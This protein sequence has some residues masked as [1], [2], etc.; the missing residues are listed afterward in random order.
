MGLMDLYQGL[1][2]RGY[3]SAQAAALVGHIQQES[4]GNPSNIN[5]R[6]GAHGL[7]Q[8]EGPRWT[9]LQNYAQSVGKPWND[10]NVQ[11]DFIG[12]EM[13]GSEAKSS[14][15]FQNAQNVQNASAALYNYIRFG[16]RSAPNRL[17]NAERI[18]NMASGGGG[19]VAPITPGGGLPFT[20]TQ[21]A[22]TSDGSLQMPTTTAAADG[23]SDGGGGGPGMGG[24]MKGLTGFANLLAK[25]EQQNQAP[26]LQPMQIPTSQAQMAKARAI[27]QAIMQRDQQAAPDQQVAQGDEQ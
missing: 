15:A 4:G 26:Q 27:A 13:S 1:I 18:F 22:S 24:I 19:D 3:S 2:A 21:T 6:E 12:H 20:P 17:A 25:S 5:Q 16:D 11:L 8:W 9:A 14:A 7:L 23:S 10:P